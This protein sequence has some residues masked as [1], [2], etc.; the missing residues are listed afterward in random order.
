MAKSEWPLHF[1]PN[2]PGRDTLPTGGSVFR[3]LKGTDEDWKSALELDRYKQHPACQ[4]A[5]LS[6]YIA[7]DE[8]RQGLRIMRRFHAI[9][10]AE[11]AS[12]HG[13]I[14]QTGQ[15]WHHSLWLRK[16]HLD[17]HSSLFTVVP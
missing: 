9:A 5:A 1:P 12:Q 3:L 7:L 14:K 16:V 8:A 4:R 13:R 2:C 17:A 10:R 6:C 15:A 11:L